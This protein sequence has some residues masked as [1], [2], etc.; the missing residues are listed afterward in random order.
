MRTKDV[1]AL[2]TLARLVNDAGDLLAGTE[3]TVLRAH[4]RR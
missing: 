1:L 4:E 3:E 2:K